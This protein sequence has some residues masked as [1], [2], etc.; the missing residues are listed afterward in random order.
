LLAL[1]SDRVLIHPERHISLSGREGSS[2]L[3][4]RYSWLTARR[5]W[6]I[7]VALA[8]LPILPVRFITEPR[9]DTPTLFANGSWREYVRPGRAMVTV[10]LP[11]TSNAIALHWQVASGLAFP[12]AEGYFVGPS[13]P[14]RDGTYGA[15]RR[16]TSLLLA[17]TAAS[18]SVP[19]IGAEQ[20]A[21]AV[22]DLRFWRADAVVLAAAP[23]VAAL[24]AS[25]D[26]LLG[27]GQDRDDVVIW[28]VRGL[29]G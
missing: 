26:Q 20:R 24:R 16:P 3:D 19:L 13:G 27:P 28:D 2:L 1:A 9:P 4:G 17:A 18:G 29:T 14:E 5:L 21:A 22:T 6:F 12:I 8:V 10:P 11:D 7:A 15:E 25:L 23:N